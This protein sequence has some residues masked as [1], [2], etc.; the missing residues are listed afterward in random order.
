MPDQ[1]QCQEGYAATTVA[2]IV[3][4]HPFIGSESQAGAAENFG[5]GLGGL[6]HIRW[7]GGGPSPE[8]TEA[9]M[10]GPGDMV[11]LVLG[12]GSGVEDN[13]VLVVTMSVEPLGCDTYAG[14]WVGG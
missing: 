13:E 8:D 1:L 11:F 9:D 2:V 12:L 10:V 4:N 5:Q 6:H 14:V 3:D 7:C